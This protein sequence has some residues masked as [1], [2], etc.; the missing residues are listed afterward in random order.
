MTARFA[1]CHSPAD[2]CGRSC[3]TGAKAIAHD[4]AFAP[5]AAA[6]VRETGLA[7]RTLVL[8]RDDDGWDAFIQAAAPLQCAGA[9]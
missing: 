9:A 4:A 1:M 8:D 6:A 2:L 5:L 7:T 3:C